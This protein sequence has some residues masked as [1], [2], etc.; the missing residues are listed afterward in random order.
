[1]DEYYHSYSDDNDTRANYDFFQSIGSMNLTAN[2][3]PKLSARNSYAGD[4]SCDFSDVF[5]GPPKYMA[6]RQSP[7]QSGKF[8]S[9]F[10]PPTFSRSKKLEESPP[11][12]QTRRIGYS[13]DFYCDIF[14][15]DSASGTSEVSITSR[16]MSRTLSPAQSPPPGKVL[17][18]RTFGTG[19]PIPKTRPSGSGS[20][21][22]EHFA[23]GPCLDSCSF[24]WPSE[25]VQGHPSYQSS[26]HDHSS[27]LMKF[28][29]GYSIKTNKT[30][31][32]TKYTQELGK[33]H[34][35]S[36]NSR[37]QSLLEP[38]E[39]VLDVPPR[40]SNEKLCSTPRSTSFA[41]T[42]DD[43]WESNISRLHRNSAHVMARRRHSSDKAK[44]D[45]SSEKMDSGFEKARLSASD[46][47]LPEHQRLYAFS[48]PQGSLIQQKTKRREW[49]AE[50]KGLNLGSESGSLSLCSS[51]VSSAKEIHTNHEISVAQLAA[52]EE[53]IL[54]RRRDS[55]VES[56]D[57]GSYVIEIDAEKG[58]TFGFLP[59]KEIQVDS[60][61][62]P[63]IPPLNGNET[64]E[65]VM[66]KSLQKRLPDSSRIDKVKA[67]R[68]KHSSGFQRNGET[69]RQSGEGNFSNVMLNAGFYKQ[70]S[71][72]IPSL[73][74]PTADVNCNK[75]I[76]EQKSFSATSPVTVKENPFGESHRTSLGDPYS[77]D[78]PNMVKEVAERIE[79]WQ[80]EKPTVFYE[81]PLAPP[82]KE[83]TPSN[84]K[85]GKSTKDV[86]GHARRLEIGR[87]KANDRSVC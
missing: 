30:F 48:P 74:I 49:M 31:H 83:K 2:A 57:L 44:V 52:G 84:V 1:M 17:E 66:D 7:K 18:F 77:I 87:H 42:S 32:G 50:S 56:D 11:F 78:I 86:Q 12:G 61:T 38:G 15:A 6:F 5:G 58:E 33:S 3:S 53:T 65:C 8:N 69:S 51:G 20:K 21:E 73:S 60:S 67:Y 34:S 85:A 80:C 72:E 35:R 54:E 43:D 64:A 36:P 46:I 28:P 29:F 62:D 25:D 55:G 63:N 70:M 27:N 75:V 37:L 24:K 45:G 14:N 9:L 19:S 4:M 10:D 23:S 59:V 16:P 81:I 79:K 71:S 39:S 22:T 40:L 13:D 26:L 82:A 41:N 68:E 76:M 47:P